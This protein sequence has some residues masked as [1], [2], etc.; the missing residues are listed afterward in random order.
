M[1]ARKKQSKR[2]PSPHNGAERHV[3]GHFAEGVQTSL[4]KLR[5]ASEKA[6]DLMGRWE[7]LT[8]GAPGLLGG[9]LLT[10]VNESVLVEQ[11]ERLSDRVA[12]ARGEPYDLAE[13]ADFFGGVLG[14]YAAL[15]K[16]L[17]GVELDPGHP[18]AA[19]WEKLSDELL[20]H[21]VAIQEKAEEL[22][23]EL[24]KDDGEPKAAG[25]AAGLQPVSRGLLHE[26]WRKKQ[27]GSELDREEARLVRILEDHPEYRV[28]WESDAAG[29]DQDY[30]IEGV[31]PFVHVT[32][33]SAVE[34]QLV[35]NEPPEVSQT[36]DRLTRGGMTR[37]DAIHRIANALVEQIWNMQREGRRFNRSAY[38]KALEKL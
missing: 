14:E 11:L 37:H 31:N 5:A 15:I 25:A 21:G 18:L 38:V 29:R 35:H 3:L 2:T 24:E 23:T 8:D 34:D 30:T 12:A 4:V 17:A 26:I 27:R 16:V 6:Q 7:Q 20:E 22:E 13:H 1:P 10:L 32:M 36:L 19:E 33:H 28:A 9:S